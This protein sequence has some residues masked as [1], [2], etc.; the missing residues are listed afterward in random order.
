MICPVTQRASSVASHATTARGVVRVAPAPL[1]RALEHLAV[2]LGA[3]P[4]GVGRAR[5]HRVHGDAAVR[6]VRSQARH[7]RLER[8]LRRCVGELAR[9]GRAALARGE[10]HQAPAGAAVVAR[11]ELLRDEQRRAHVH[12]EVP[13]DLVSGER[14]QCRRRSSKRG[15]APPRRAGRAATSP[16]PRHAPVSPGRL[17]PPRPSRLARRRAELAGQRLG[18]VRVRAPRAVRVVRRERVQAQIRAQRREA[19]GD[20]KPDPGA[21]R[22]AG[23]E[24]PATAE[25]KCTHARH[26]LTEG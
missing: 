4:A 10:Q 21:P 1:R 19:L 8:A 24:S 12:D 20:R 6:E 25:R 22:H 3:G 2:D 14:L 26:S 13:V 17:D 5:I 16:R 15:S 7:Q 9:H 11:G 23:D 18:P